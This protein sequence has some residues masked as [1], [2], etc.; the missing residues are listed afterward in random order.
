MS[1]ALKSY[2]RRLNEIYPNAC[3]SPVTLQDAKLVA[4]EVNLASAEKKQIRALAYSLDV[5]CPDEIE[6]SQVLR[7]LEDWLKKSRENAVVAVLTDALHS[8]NLGE[9]ISRCFGDL[10]KDTLLK[11]PKTQEIPS[12]KA[13]L[14]PSTTCLYGKGLRL[15]AFFR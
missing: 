10:G 9:V 14:P 11:A 6:A 13:R 5:S 12:S 15:S 3:G 7:L 2:G 8:S 4:N 1:I